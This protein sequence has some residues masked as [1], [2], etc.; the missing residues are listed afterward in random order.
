[1]N[2][3]IAHHLVLATVGTNL[4]LIHHKVILKIEGDKVMKIPQNKEKWENMFRHR[5]A[6]VMIQL[7]VFLVMLAFSVYHYVMRD[8][9]I[10]L[11]LM[12][13]ALFI[14][15]SFSVIGAH[16]NKKWKNPIPEVYT[17]LVMP[18]FNE[19]PKVVKNSLES[20]INQTRLP[21]TVY[22]IDDCS[23]NVD[24]IER[25]YSDWHKKAV[26]LG[27]DCRIHYSEKNQ[28]KREAQAIAFKEMG[29]I[30]GVFVTVDS[31]TVLDNEAISEGL[32]P[33]GDE[34]VMAVAGLLVCLN[35]NKILPKILELPFIASFVTGR[36]FWSTFRSLAV[37]CGGLAFFRGNV[38]REHLDDYL[39][40]RILGGHKAKF[41][42]DRM[43]TQ[44]ASLHGET[45]FQESSV[46]HT[47]IPENFSHL[48]RQRLRWW[49]SFWWGGFWVLKNHTVKKGIWWLI[50]SQYLQYFIFVPIIIA[51]IISS[52]VSM[53]VPWEIFVYM[54]LLS[55]VRMGRTLIIERK[56]V[57]LTKQILELLIFAP[58]A[59]L[60]Y[61]Y[62]SVV[63]QTYSLIT[64][65]YNGWG[66]RK[67]VEVKMDD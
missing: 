14:W 46:G 59:S 9:S 8:P 2:Q 31:D 23:D 62:L 38:I 50:I 41:G 17:T 52:I 35:N 37:A 30:T 19:D 11:D 55:Y 39:N 15:L 33:F 58:I 66:T 45:V 49:R 13:I 43:L 26:N 53:R 10:W 56:G 6:Y 4:F 24:E 34:K 57:T 36:A 1:M 18:I 21:D 32:K 42:D 27:I 61:I 28:G 25:I 22:L 51:I 54:M 47:L 3:Y 63:L 48:T 44:Y 16:L 60:V 29:D 67:N 5:K 40:Q 20:I 12:V 7:L 64:I 65:K